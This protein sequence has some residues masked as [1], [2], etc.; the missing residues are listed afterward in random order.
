MNYSDTIQNDARGSVFQTID[1]IDYSPIAMNED[2]T[3][4]GNVVADMQIMVAKAIHD[5]VLVD[6]DD[7]QT[8]HNTLDK[9][10]VE[11]AEAGDM[12]YEPELSCNGDSMHHVNKG[13]I[14]IRVEDTRGFDISRNTIRNIENLSFPPYDKCA[15]FHD[16]TS[17]ENPGEQGNGNVRAISVAATRGFYPL[18]NSIIADNNIR[19]VRSENGMYVVGVD[20]QGE[21][22]GI[23]VNRNDVDLGPFDTL[24]KVDAIALRVRK[25]AY[26]A[27]INVAN[28]NLLAQAY[29]NLAPLQKIR[30]RQTGTPHVSEIEWK[31]GGCPYAHGRRPRVT[32]PANPWG[33]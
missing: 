14:V 4:K 11:W 6:T 20:I 8:I 28:D 18:M 22:A 21:S 2:G 32:R 13:I 10:F 1:S 30:T 3:Y 23:D 26:R 27:T 19:G 24:S 16:G 5:E 9:H 7:L 29:K 15:S 33:N 25:N 31:N 17:E 12:V